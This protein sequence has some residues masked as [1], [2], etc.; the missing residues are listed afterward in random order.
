MCPAA[1]GCSDLG[2]GALALGDPWDQFTNAC[3]NDGDCAG[4]G[5]SYDIG[6]A[7]RDLT[8]LDAI[9][10][11][12]DTLA[13]GR[14]FSRR[15]FV[16]TAVGSGFAAAVLPTLP[17]PEPGSQPDLRIRHMARRLRQL[18]RRYHSVLCVC[19]LLDWPWLREAFVER[20]PVDGVEIRA[21]KRF[22]VSPFLPM[23]MRYDWRFSVPGEQLDVHM[24]NRSGD[25]LVFD[26]TL[27]L[28]REPLNGATLARFG[29]TST[30]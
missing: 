22:H 1:S 12:I 21:E 9:Q 13:P 20:R 19:S 24:E 18:E 11:D 14:G 29:L 2:P 7:L 17:R 23:D 10:D 30:S 26:A 15:A 25:T 28:H 16:G 27:T 3:S 6:K 8:G 4:V 5:V